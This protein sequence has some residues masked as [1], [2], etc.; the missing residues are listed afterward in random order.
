MAASLPKEGEVNARHDFFRNFACKI[1][2]KIM[3]SIQKIFLAAIGVVF[4]HYK[5][6]KKGFCYALSFQKPFNFLETLPLSIF[7]KKFVYKLF[8][9]LSLRKPF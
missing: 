3:S 6:V 8:P 4:I 2:K 5:I 7:P 9:F 1:S